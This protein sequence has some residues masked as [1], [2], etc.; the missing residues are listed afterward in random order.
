MAFYLFENDV[1]VTSDKLCDLFSFSGLN[2]VV[3]ILI[4]SKV[5]KYKDMKLKRATKNTNH[6]VN[7][8]SHYKTVTIV[9]MIQSCRSARWESWSCLILQ[10]VMQLC[11]YCYTLHSFIR[12]NKMSKCHLRFR[13][14]GHLM[15]MM[16]LQSRHR[17]DQKRKKKGEYWVRLSM[18]LQR[19]WGQTKP[20]SNYWIDLALTWS[21]CQ[22]SKSWI[23]A[24]LQDALTSSQKHI[25]LHRAGAQHWLLLQLH[26]LLHQTGTN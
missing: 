19:A 4:V 2:G 14:A 3:T 25:P 11:C 26:S 17:I 13:K 7:N 15:F 22:E 12:L 1:N 24:A 21:R 6:S 8:T 10:Y 9:W 16:K 5:L 20:S 23:S 18:Q